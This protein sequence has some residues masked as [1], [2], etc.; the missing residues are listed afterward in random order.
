MGCSRSNPHPLCWLR[1]GSVFA[2][3]RQIHPTQPSYTRN[4]MALGAWTTNNHMHSPPTIAPRQHST[5][6]SSGITMGE[7]CVLHCTHTSAHAAHTC[8]YKRMKQRHGHRGMP[9]GG[10]RRVKE[11]EESKDALL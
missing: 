8:T 5:S 9:A 4:K 11:K 7:R 3:R 2:A 6:N 1:V 10:V